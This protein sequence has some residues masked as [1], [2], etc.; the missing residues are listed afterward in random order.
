MTARFHFI[1]AMT[2]VLVLGGCASR[3]PGLEPPSGLLKLGLPTTSP[4]SGSTPGTAANGSAVPESVS[5]GPLP[6]NAPQTL[7]PTTGVT[8]NQQMLDKPQDRPSSI[9][10]DAGSAGDR[11]DGETDNGQL[12]YPSALERQWAKTP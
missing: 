10:A 2:P 11:P 4:D 5:Q 1:G 3:E 8:K 7:R 12:S 9:Q 6:S